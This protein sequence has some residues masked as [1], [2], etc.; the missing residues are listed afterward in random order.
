M[1]VITGL[2][3]AARSVLQNL[4]F[5]STNRSII[6]DSI[7]IELYYY[8]TL[9]PFLLYNMKNAELLEKKRVISII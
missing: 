9:P 5:P 8:Y 7:I 4:L 1:L 2:F 6:L 3:A